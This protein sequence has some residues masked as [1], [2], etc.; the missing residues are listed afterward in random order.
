MIRNFTSF[1][2]HFFSGIATAPILFAAEEYPQLNL[3]ISRQFSEQNDVNQAREI[4]GNSYGLQK[5]RKLAQNYA[6]DAIKA[7]NY[8]FLFS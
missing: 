5:T 1:A 6:Y 8:L 4:V 3:F 2:Y 7:V